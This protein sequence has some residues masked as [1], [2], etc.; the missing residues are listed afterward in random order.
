MS[1]FQ[2]GLPVRLWVWFNFRQ[3]RLHWRR[4]VSV[5]AGIGLGA[6]V[7]TSVR[8]AVNASLDSFT[9][10]VDAITGRADLTVS[11]PGGHVPEDV[12]PRL[13][14]H[15]AVLTASPILS[16]YVRLGDDD[17]EPFL[18]V[19]IDPL[20]DRPLRTGPSPAPDD[21]LPASAWVG[22]VGR[23]YTLLAGW[24][25]AGKNTPSGIRPGDR[26]A[27]RHVSRKESFE[28][29]GTLP[30]AG[31]GLVDDGHLAVTDIATMQEFMGLLGWVD[32][33]DILLRPGATSNELDEIAEL[34][35]KGV[36]PGQPGESRE[37]GKLLIRSYQL[38]LSVLSFVSLFVGMF[39]VYSMMS[40]HAAS[41]RH[42]LAVL[43]SIGASSR[44]VFFLFLAEGA[45]FGVAGWV[46]A[47]PVAAVAVQQMLGAVSSTITHL[48]ARVQVDRLT[49]D[50]S[51]LVLSFVVTVS[52]AL[53][54]A[55][56]PAR[57]AMS[58]PPREVFLA[59]EPPVARRTSLQL[60]L[61]GL[62]AVAVAYPVSG[63]PPLGGVP[64]WGYAAT[65]LLF[66]GFSLLSP[67]CL[68]IAGTHLPH[69][70]NRCFG[71]P[72]Y[73]GCRTMR[74]A[75][76][77]V[78]IP[79]GALITAVGLFVALTIMV[80]SFR[81]TVETWV[82]Q[83]FSGELFV[84]PKMSDINRYRDPLPPEVVR[85]LRELD[86]SAELLPYRRIHLLYGKIPYQFE[87]VDFKVFRRHARF[88]FLEGDPNTVQDRLAEGK[89]V[90]V[91]EVFAN[92]TGLRPGDHFRAQIE[93]VRLDLP[94]LGIVRDYRTTGGIVEYSLP[95]FQKA[96]GDDSW[97]GSRVFA[98]GAGGRGDVTG[99]HLRDEFLAGIGPFRDAMEVLSGEELRNGILRLFDETFAI[100]GVLL[101]I[102]LMIAALGIATTLT[103]L[104]LDRTKELQTLLAVGAGRGQ[105]RAMIC[106]EAILM[107][108]VG[109]CLGAGCG[110]LLSHLLIFVINRQSFGWTFLYDVD[111]PFFAG[112][113]P[114]I[115]LT[116][117]LAALPA[118]RIIFRQP[119]SAA[120][121]DQ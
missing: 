38:N 29:L 53:L 16:T 93:G 54:A 18:L 70:L 25:L 75:G 96:T 65:F 120:L 63:L 98:S 83:T 68:R 86:P 121:R 13:L 102:A 76:M 117:I 50:A 49:L 2:P 8:L 5:I 92:Q 41:R 3:L 12:V 51:E 99:V 21:S 97:S 94:V 69:F 42:E 7:F 100:T 26:L 67:L 1:P 118:S 77:R 105:L 109:E 79:V 57:T 36:L 52:V 20:L 28:I 73:L 58:A 64:L 23:P 4:T 14:K 45:F 66:C 55:F 56:Q 59:A 17:R 84:R 95:E 24:A 40:L 46:A 106:W 81:N 88:L 47:I 10:S 112:S 9:R 27:I 30:R 119:P 61:F 107:V 31:L 60:G 74:D 85:A 19:G 114:T 101:A 108:L 82:N 33:V 80:H 72:A 34:L 103:V 91:S 43:R 48:F 116:A 87:A 111:W 37:S 11:C 71:L 110:L 89:G 62:L 6:A 113:L 104:V 44:L 35:P 15:P 115:L 22:L 90:L 39:L 32:R 78:A